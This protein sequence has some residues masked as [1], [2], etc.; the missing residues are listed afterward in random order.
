MKDRTVA[1]YRVSKK[2][3]SGSNENDL[4]TQRKLVQDYIYVNNLNL[5]REFTEG[6]V[7]G[8]RSLYSDREAIVSILEMAQNQEFDILV[9]YH[10]SRLSRLQDD[11]LLIIKQLNEYDIRVLSTVEGELKIDTLADRLKNNIRFFG[12]EQ[13]SALKSEIISDYH[14]AMVKEGRYRGGAMLPYGYKLENNGNRNYKGRPILDFMI[15]EDEAKVVRMIY[16]MSLYDGYGQARIA[17]KLNELKINSKKGGIW[18]NSGICSILNN[19]IYKGYFR[20]RSKVRDKEVLSPQKKELVIISEEEWEQNQ[21]IMSSRK[22]GSDTV[23]KKDKRSENKCGKMLL[24]GIAICG[25]CGSSLTTMTV[26]SR[27]S[28]KD[29]VKH[30]TADYRYRCG[31][32]Y[33]RGGVKCEGQS[34]Y[35]RAKLDTA[36]INEVNAYVMELKDRV[37]EGNFLA[38]LDRNIYALEKR[39]KTIQNSLTGT[40]SGIKVLRSEVVKALT[41]Q[42][43]FTE[44]ILSES[45]KEKEYEIKQIEKAI[46]DNNAAIMKLKAER[47]LYQSYI[48]AFK[49]WTDRFNKSTIEKKR[50]ML[51]GILENVIVEKG[52]IKLTFK[53]EIETFKNNSLNPIYVNKTDVPNDALNI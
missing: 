52:R 38:N 15:D 47:E 10:S 35:S 28:T 51:A 39:G 27:W 4:P 3:Q 40:Y 6:G 49:D 43:N 2:Q 16:A 23:L 9:V 33:K 20:M 31:S 26:Y 29:E 50:L 42:S 12:N 41:S 1:L 22:F 17:N 8:Y 48:S 45:I 44:E 30:K 32:F 53:K 21:I 18:T 11:T 25:Y 34:T 24:N 5:V 14:I 19:P 46:R 7:S 37:L 13:E 36:V